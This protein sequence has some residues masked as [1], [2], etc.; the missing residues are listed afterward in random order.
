MLSA[1]D[2]PAS[3][4]MGTTFGT[5][6]ALL[7]AAGFAANVVCVFHIIS[8][9]KYKRN[10]SYSL[11]LN[12]LSIKS[13]YGIFTCFHLLMDSRIRGSYLYIKPSDG[14]CK[15]SF[16]SEIFGETGEVFMLFLIWLIILSERKFVGFQNFCANMSSSFH[17]LPSNSVIVKEENEA[18]A[19]QSTARSLPVNN[20][21][22]NFLKKFLF[23]FY[24]INFIGSFGI[25]ISG[26]LTELSYFNKAYCTAPEAIGLLV[27]VIFALVFLPIVYTIII[28]SSLLW[29]LFGGRLD[30]L[31]A[32]L[33]WSEANFIKLLK[34]LSL[35][36]GAEMFFMDIRSSVSFFLLESVV[37]LARVLSLVLS[38]L[39]AVIFIYFEMTVTPPVANQVRRG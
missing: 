4:A 9:S 17:P 2:P 24:L 13:V 28:C 15:L 1:A 11:M 14:L 37:E 23:G 30:P 32:K 18:L 21:S 33:T 38:I 20:Y 19:N 16:I 29:N 35:L 5:L 3:T 27:L 25:G 7:S 8:S 26:E 22:K 31:V 34:I 36:K 12:Y 10:S 39:S 6:F